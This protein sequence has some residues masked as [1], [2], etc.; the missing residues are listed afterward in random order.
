MHA[1]G[2]KI[3]VMTI[4]MKVARLF[5]VE[6]LCSGGGR[7]GGGSSDTGLGRKLIKQVQTS[8]RLPKSAKTS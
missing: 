5:W 3:Q 2:K 1:A 6:N 8:S 4:M 7:S